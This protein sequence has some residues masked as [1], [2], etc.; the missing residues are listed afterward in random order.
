[1]IVLPNEPLQPSAG[2]VAHVTGYAGSYPFDVTW[3]FRTADDELGEVSPNRRS[4]CVR[5]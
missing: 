2:Y 3:G 5:G 1:M 4:A